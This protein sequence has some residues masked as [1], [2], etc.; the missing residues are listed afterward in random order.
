MTSD[1]FDLHLDDDLSRG[2][3]TP[4]PDEVPSHVRELLRVVGSHARQHQMLRRM[5]WAVIAAV[6]FGSLGVIG[7]VA[8]AAW[9]LGGRMERLESIAWRVER[10]ERMEDEH[11]R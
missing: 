4:T 3:K 6:A 9:S 5:I 1:L 10:L 2:P 11:G 7:A 8:G